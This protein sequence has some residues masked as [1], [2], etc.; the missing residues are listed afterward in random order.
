M[1]NEYFGKG[2]YSLAFKKYKMALK[3]V[4]DGGD[5]KQVA[6]TEYQLPI[7]LNQS[8]CSFKL[9]KYSDAISE[10]SKALAIEPK[11]VKGLYRKGLAQS[12][13]K[14]W[15]DA[16]ASFTQALALEPD[17]Q[18]VKTSLAKTKKLIAQYEAQERARYKNLFDRM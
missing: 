1:G 3:F 15:E 17:N 16:V 14:L 6:E 2:E 7:L 11:S 5:H 9:G 4:E 10:A 8:A 18:P 12:E 13:S